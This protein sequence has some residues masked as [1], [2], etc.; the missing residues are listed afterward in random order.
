MIEKRDKVCCMHPDTCSPDSSLHL[1]PR[2]A[3]SKE[4]GVLCVFTAVHQSWN[5]R[6]LYLPKKADVNVT[7]DWPPVVHGLA[8]GGQSCQAIG[9]LLIAAVAI[10][11]IYTASSACYG[12]AIYCNWS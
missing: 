12:S 1:S 10:G 11:Q 8:S 2:S 9:S 5:I 7:R 6:Y 3:T 4:V